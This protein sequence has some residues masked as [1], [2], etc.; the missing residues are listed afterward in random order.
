MYFHAETQKN[1]PF[2]GKMILKMTK[3]GS[4]SIHTQ[5]QS[6]VV[7]CLTPSLYAVYGVTVQ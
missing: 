2:H 7:E 4:A 5:R 3:H 1:T 6:Y